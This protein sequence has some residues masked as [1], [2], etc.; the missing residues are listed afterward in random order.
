VVG[1]VALHSIAKAMRMAD[2]TEPE[3]VLDAMEDMEIDTPFGPTRYRAIDNQSNMGT[4]LG[5]LTVKDG[6]PRMV[7]WTYKH[8]SEYL[9]SDERVRELRAGE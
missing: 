8:G 4:F 9:P 2:S 1:Y 6:K 7:D 3:A 5:R